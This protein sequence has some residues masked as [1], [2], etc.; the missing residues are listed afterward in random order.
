[1]QNNQIVER[2]EV[3]P[4]GKLQLIKWEEEKV[5]PSSFL[6]NNYLHNDHE[7]LLTLQKVRVDI[8]FFL[9]NTLYTS[10]GLLLDKVLSV[11]HHGSVDL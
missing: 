3:F 8:L 9:L 1:M 11:S 10:Y 6:N 5:R 4:Y 7:L 2:G